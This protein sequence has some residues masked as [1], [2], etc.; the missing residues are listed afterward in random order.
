[1]AE[2]L[3][4]ELV[5]KIM[6]IRHE[7]LD[8]DLARS[9]TRFSYAYVMDEMLRN[10]RTAKV[11]VEWLRI[12]NTHMAYTMYSRLPGIIDVDNELVSLYC[13]VLTMT[14]IY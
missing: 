10:A 1:M 14:D 6:D 3:P 4:M 13:Y 8:F 9:F 2:T 11:I 7:M 12:G 5:R